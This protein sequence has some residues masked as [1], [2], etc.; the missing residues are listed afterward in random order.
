MVSEF[1]RHSAMAF[2]ACRIQTMVMGTGEA[3]S[4]KDPFD[5]RLLYSRSAAAWLVILLAFGFT[6]DGMAASTNRIDIKVDAARHMLKGTAV[7]RFENPGP[8]ASTGSLEDR[9]NRGEDLEVIHFQSNPMQSS[10]IFTFNPREWHEVRRKA[11]NV[12]VRAFWQDA[13]WEKWIPRLADLACNAIEF[14][15]A[16]FHRYPARSLCVVPGSLHSTGGA[17]VAPGIITN[18]DLEQLGATAGSF[19]RW[20]VA[21]EVGHECFGEYV[22]DSLGAGYAQ[23]SISIIRLFVED[24]KG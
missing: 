5:G 4:K 1:D 9:E 6:S 16:E 11:G 22:L 21:H 20:I 23:G 19:A 3:L 17:P 8:Y 2:S 7:V 15:G 18:H 14:Y 12:Q 10:R 13:R 24:A